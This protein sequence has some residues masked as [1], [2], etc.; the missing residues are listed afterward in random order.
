MERGGRRKQAV[1]SHTQKLQFF[2]S[3]N[4]QNNTSTHTA[5]WGH[6]VKKVHSTLFVQRHSY[7]HVWVANV[8]RVMG[9]VV[10]KKIK[11]EKNPCCRRKIGGVSIKTSV[12]NTTIQNE[13]ILC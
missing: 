13:A 7:M 10:N 4:E 12:K 11:T 2:G 5:A 8:G 6:S 9:F 3:E 1:S